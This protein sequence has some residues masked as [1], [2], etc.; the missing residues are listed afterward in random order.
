M[1]QHEYPLALPGP[2]VGT[3]EAEL[4]LLP[5]SGSRLLRLFQEIMSRALQCWR[6]RGRRR[7]WP[8]IQ[9]P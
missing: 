5:H 3:A 8:L 4:P 7:G 2:A 1:T 6:G 9:A